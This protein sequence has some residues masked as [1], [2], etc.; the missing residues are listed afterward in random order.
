MTPPRP[1]TAAAG[2]LVQPIDPYIA[3]GGRDAAE[4]KARTQSVNRGA[5]RAAVLGVNDGLV[6]NLSL[7]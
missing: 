4:L 6:T 3:D 5:A 1:K 7:M 2:P